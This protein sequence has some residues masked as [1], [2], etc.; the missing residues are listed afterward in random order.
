MI[1]QINAEVAALFVK[2]PLRKNLNK[3]LK[4]KPLELSATIASITNNGVFTIIFNKDIYEI[5][6][7][8]AINSDVLSIKTLAGK[9]SDPNNLNITSW[10]VTSNS[11]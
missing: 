9:D 1:P 2:S 4:T 7:L 10:N 3:N 5:K 11:F 6:N 8:S